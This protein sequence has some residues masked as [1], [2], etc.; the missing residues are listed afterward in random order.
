MTNFDFEKILDTSDEWIV[1]RTGI[2]KRHFAAEDEKCSDLAYKAGLAALE[3]AGLSASD[4][5]LIIVATGHARY[6]LPM[7]GVESAGDAWRCERRDLRC[8]CG[9][10]RQP[11]RDDH[12]DR[13]HIQR[14]LERTCL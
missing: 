7:H 6:S 2:R 11:Y 5:D 12:S 8:A 14:N 9:L 13:R 4:L 3:D 1:T 10:H